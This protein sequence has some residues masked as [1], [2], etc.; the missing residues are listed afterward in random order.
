MIKIDLITGFLG[1]GKT[2]FIKK[3]A[4]YLLNQNEK[5]CIIEND[6][7]SINVD[8]L[9][10]NEVRNDRCEIEMVTGGSDGTTHK[11]RLK[12][13]L[14]QLAMQGYTRVIV[15]PSG[16]FD[17]DDFFDLLYEEPLDNWYEIGTVMMILDP[18]SQNYSKEEAYI[19]TSEVSHA[20]IVVISKS[21]NYDKQYITR[22]IEILKRTIQLYNCKHPVS[23]VLI[24]NWDELTNEDYNVIKNSSYKNYSYLKQSISDQFES[25]FYFDIHYPIEVIKEK[26][27]QL[28]FNEECGKIMRIKGC[29]LVDEGYYVEINAT[30]NE[31]TIKE[32]TESQ[33]VIIVIGENLNKEKIKELI[34]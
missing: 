23:K 20:G 19:L 4:Q 9:F 32:I 31:M 6:Y 33:K 12:A 15:E 26:I 13:K 5:V 8:M 22:S 10:L 29:M 18:S 28:F 11:R 7:G 34:K 30:H 21:Q 17:V 2:T 25:V 16:I 14:I 27:Q 3:Y 1:S 24:K